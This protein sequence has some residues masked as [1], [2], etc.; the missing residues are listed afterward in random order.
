[1]KP[2]RQR[3]RSNFFG[4]VTLGAKVADAIVE[5]STRLREARIGLYSIS[6]MSSE[7]GGVSFSLAPPA[8]MMTSSEAPQQTRVRQG[9]NDSTDGSNYKDF[10]FMPDEGGCKIGLHTRDPT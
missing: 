8:P 9:M 10:C 7:K 5:I 1:V 2:L 4:T 3:V 6:S